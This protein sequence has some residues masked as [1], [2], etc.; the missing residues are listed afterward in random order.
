[1]PLSKTSSIAK[2]PAISVGHSHFLETLHSNT[3]NK[4]KTLC[5]F[6]DLQTSSYNEPRQDLLSV[7]RHGCFPCFQKSH[8]TTFNHSILFPRK[9][10]K[11]VIL[12]HCKTP[13]IPPYCR[14]A[15]TKHLYGSKPLQLRTE[16]YRS[17]SMELW[18]PKIHLFI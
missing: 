18:R 14:E 12:L 15:L 4:I 2:P 13:A 5:D 11:Y 17:N 16:D 10:R 8:S 9:L 1:M 7:H 3:L 6:S